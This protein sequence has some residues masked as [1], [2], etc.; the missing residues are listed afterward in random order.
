M[1]TKDIKDWDLEDIKE[2]IEAQEAKQKM[3]DP[4]P[5]T[6]K[7]PPF[8]NPMGVMGVCGECGI[9]LYDVMG[10]VCPRPFCPTGLGGIMCHAGVS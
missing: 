8:P 6:P 3:R 5:E 10:Y 1:P 2:W 9:Q 4:L 7:F